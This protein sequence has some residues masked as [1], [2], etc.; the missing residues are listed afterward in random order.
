MNNLQLRFEL[1][2]SL[3]QYVANVMQQYQIPASMMEDALNK[4]LLE[5]KEQVWIDYLTEQ[6]Q[7]MYEAQIAVQQQQEASVQEEQEEE[8][9][10]ELD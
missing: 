6:Q 7:A 2:A 4:L 10:G 3:Q 9:N 8:V 1:Q 5:I